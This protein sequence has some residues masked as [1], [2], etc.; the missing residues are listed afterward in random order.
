MP[1]RRTL[2]RP[3]QRF[4]GSVGNIGSGCS[5]GRLYDVGPFWKESI[6]KSDEKATQLILGL[7]KKLGFEQI[8]KARDLW[9]VLRK[10][11]HSLQ[12]G[13][14]GDIFIDES[15]RCIQTQGK[16]RL[17]FADDLFAKLICL[18]SEVRDKIS[19][20]TKEDKNVL[21]ELLPL[22]V[23][24]ILI[25]EFL[26]EKEENENFLEQAKAT[27]GENGNSEDSK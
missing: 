19:T 25:S 14:H 4:V 3:A 1:A 7:F 22:E 6:L 23:C 2:V 21:N 17:P 5:F 16:E 18:A 10:N 20:L 12:I 8:I 13:T 11:G 9:W 27:Y 26:K 24:Q 15:S